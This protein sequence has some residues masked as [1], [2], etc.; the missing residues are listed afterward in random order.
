MLN[1][2][3]SDRKGLVYDL[4]R[5]MKDIHIRVAYGK[6]AVRPGS[7]CEVDLFVQEVDGNRILDKCAPPP[8]PP[9]QPFTCCRAKS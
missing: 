4:M 8:S 5:T 3:C 9:P 6:V 7:L 1:V 2:I